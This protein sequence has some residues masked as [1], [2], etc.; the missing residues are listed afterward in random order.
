M[1]KEKGKCMFC[2]YEDEKGTGEQLSAA[3]WLCNRCA[4]FWNKAYKNHKSN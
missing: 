3:D 2:E 4:W 1:K